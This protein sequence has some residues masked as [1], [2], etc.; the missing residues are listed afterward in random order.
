MHHPGFSCPLCRTF[1]DL[2][3]DVE[4]EDLAQ[5]IDVV[6]TL[7]PPNPSLN[8][9]PCP[10][11]SNLQTEHSNEL[12]IH[13]AMIGAICPDPSFIT[14]EPLVSAQT[15]YPGTAPEVAEDDH[16]PEVH[17]TADNT[18]IL[19]SMA[20]SHLDR[21]KTLTGT[22]LN[23][24]GTTP[25][26][27]QSHVADNLRS[28][29]LSMRLVEETSGS[30][31]PQSGDQQQ[32]G[33]SSSPSSS[34]DR[35]VEEG[36]EHRRRPS[37][38]SVDSIINSSMSTD[39]NNPDSIGLM[40]HIGRPDPAPHPPSKGRKPKTGLF[41]AGTHVGSDDQSRR[42]EAG[43]HQNPDRL[44][45]IDG[46]RKSGLN[47]NYNLNIAPD[48]GNISPHLTL[49][50]SPPPVPVVTTSLAGGHVTTPSN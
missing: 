16:D 47:S 8:Q 43:D 37:T 15:P 24:S 48:L 38:H 44:V 45:M 40:N 9:A 3:A 1:A 19:T 6:S 4:T 2:E 28:S 29:T 30:P 26:A 33:G 7:T 32:Q 35:N 13:S 34:F 50:S 22:M 42:A 18:V 12:E 49:T 31:G 20:K 36:N 23:S 41:A 39:D 46:T 10:L 11:P 14:D 21:S 5:P 27:R 25:T 17:E